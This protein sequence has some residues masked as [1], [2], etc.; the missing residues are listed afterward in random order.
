MAIKWKKFSR[1]YVLRAVLN[2]MLLVCMVVECVLFLGVEAAYNNEETLEMRELVYNNTSFQEDFRKNLREV[3]RVAVLQSNEKEKQS[4]EQKSKGKYYFYVQYKE[5]DGQLRSWQYSDKMEINKDGIPNDAT[6]TLWVNYSGERNGNDYAKEWNNIVYDFYLDET[7]PTNFYWLSV[8]N[9]LVELCQE[10]EKVRQAVAKNM[11]DDLV[12]YEDYLKQFLG[13]LALEGNVEGYDKI[14]MTTYY[15]IYG[16]Y[17][18]AVNTTVEILKSQ[19]EDVDWNYDSLSG[20]YYQ[21]EGRYLDPVEGIWIDGESKKYRQYVSQMD[22]KKLELRSK[23]N[24]VESDEKNLFGLTD[25]ELE[26]IQ[27]DISIGLTFSSVSME[28]T[29]DI[30][31]VE[32]GVYGVKTT[33]KLK[34]SVPI[35]VWLNNPHKYVIT[36]GVEQQQFQAVFGKQ[37]SVMQTNQQRNLAKRSNI[38]VYETLGVICAVVFVLICL[39]LCYVCGR[40]YGTEQVQ[41]LVW[42][43]CKT[44]FLLAAQ[45]LVAVMGS[46][47]WTAMNDYYCEYL[48]EREWQYLLLAGVVLLIELQLFYSLVRKIKAKQLY[49][50]SILAWLLGRGA[51]VLNKGRLDL[52]ATVCMVIFGVFFYIIQFLILESGYSNDLF[53]FVGEA[54]ILVMLLVVFVFVNRFTRRLSLLLEGTKRMR[55]GELNYQIATD[56][57]KGIINSIS[58]DVNQMSEGL[59]HAVEDM[60]KSERLKTELISNVSHDIKTPLTSIITYVDLLKR[61]DIKPEKA[62]EYVE[63]LDQKSQRL[64]VLTD[65]LFEAAKATSGATATD[66]V[67]LDMGALLSQAI[68]EFEER[69]QKNDLTIVSSVEREKYFVMADGRLAWR[70]LENLLSNVNK[71]ALTSSRVYIDCQLEEEMVKLIVKN[72]SAY[73]LNISAE[74]LLERFT[75]GDKSRNTEGSGL[76]LNIAKSLAELQN[77]DFKI[78]VD[79]DLFKAILELPVA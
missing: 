16:D 27:K 25:K 55:A 44:E 5:K 47:A 45:I 2:V 74:E 68:G 60:L 72:I 59:E 66:I 42:D 30:E 43:R 10:D 70:I 35:S 77:G 8:N 3:L 9:I 79:G 75:R 23:T 11:V 38:K 71:Y 69:F 53:F 67:R 15:K 52:R 40:K 56:Q 54:I 57:S 28:D 4:V 13:S 64:K 7:Q 1:S 73:E 22:E 37:I 14:D 34:L 21:Y 65:D 6:N 76:G 33:N 58:K 31:A 26:H 18:E 48:P 32:E 29:E 17:P 39:F 46:L 78:Q 61:E 36:F 51:G 62:K 20:L 50:N 12:V 49:G 41:L 19:Y 63:V 24:K